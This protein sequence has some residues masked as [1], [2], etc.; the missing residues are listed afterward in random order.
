LKR[1]LALYDDAVAFVGRWW[2]SP[3]PERA[4]KARKEGVSILSPEADDDS[5]SAVRRLVV[6][7][8]RRNAGATSTISRMAVHWAIFWYHEK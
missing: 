1:G 3:R 5:A 4:P 6:R 7:F 2:N 8:H